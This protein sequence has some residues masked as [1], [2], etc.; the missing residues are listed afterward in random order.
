MHCNKLYTAAS[1]MKSLLV[2]F[3]TFNFIAFV[4]ITMQRYNKKLIR[5]NPQKL[6]LDGQAETDAVFVVNRN[7]FIPLKQVLQF[8]DV[9]I[10]TP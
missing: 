2:N 7:A 4:L 8:N 3:V 10:H 9:N 5:T 1:S 6:F